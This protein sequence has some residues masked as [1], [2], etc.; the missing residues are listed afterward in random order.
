[1][2]A[3]QNEDQAV[4]L[5]VLRRLT[6]LDRLLAPGLPLHQ[7]LHVTAQTTGEMLGANV[8]V[9]YQLHPET[10]I[11]LVPPISWGELHQPQMLST[12]PERNAAVLEIM[13]RIEPFYAPNAPKGWG[14][15]LGIAPEKAA[16]GF[17]QR[18]QIVSSAGVPLLAGGRCLGV[19]FVNFR[20]PCQFNPVEKDLIEL[21]AARAVLAMQNTQQIEQERRT[22]RHISMAI[23]SEA[24]LEEAAGKILDELGKVVVYRKATMQLI[25][26]DNRKLLAYRGFEAENIDSELLRPISKDNL[27][28]R[29]V[30]NE[31]PTI[32][33]NPLVDPAWEVHSLTSDARSWVGV[34]LRFAGRLVGLITLDHDQPSFYSS[35]N[36]D[37]L[38]WCAGQAAIAIENARLHD[39]AQ[40]RIRDLRILNEI[41]E[42]IGS[43]LN[44]QDLLNAIA[45]RIRKHLQCTSCTFFFP[46]PI[47]DKMLL[48]PAVVDGDH[49]ERILSRTFKPGEGLVGLVY[50]SGEAI[51]LADARDHQNYAPARQR[52][53]VPRSMM[54]VPVQM[55]GR[56]V[57]VISADQD[58]YGWFSDNDLRLL[59]ALARQAGIA[60]QRNRGLE[61]LGKIGRRI[62]SAENVDEILKL[63]V[64]GAIDLSN[65]TSGVIYLVSTDGRQIIKTYKYPKKSFHPEPRMDKADGLTRQVIATGQIM[66]LVDVPRD[67]RVNPMLQQRV[68]SMIALPLKHED[69]VTGVLF[70]K[71]QKAHDFTETEIS[72]LSTLADQAATALYKAVLLTGLA[73]Q[74]RMHETLNAVELKLSGLHDEVQILKT[75]ARSTAKTLNCR[76]CSVFRVEHNSL[77]VV[78]SHGKLKSQLPP[79][80]T[81][82]LGQGIAGWVAQTGKP[83]LVPDTERDERFEP[84][85][86]EP[87]SRSSVITPIILDDEVYGVISAEDPRPL[88]FDEQDLRL[89]QT[90]AL[91]VSQALRNAQRITELEAL[92][93]AGRAITRELNL[94]FLFETLLGTV[95]QTLGCLSA[96]LFII[97]ANGDLVTHTQQGPSLHELDTLR[98]QVGRGLVGW[99]AEHRTSLNVADVRQDQ[100][101]IP[102][103][104]IPLDAPHSMLLAP[105][106]FKEH[107]VGV[108]S[109]DKDIVGG[110]S[111]SDQRLLETLA[112]QAATAYENARLFQE[113][114]QQADELALLHDVSARL[115]TLDLNDLL[116]MILEGAMRLTHT[117]V[118]VIYLL[119]EDG[120]RITQSLSRPTNF[121]PATFDLS[122]TH[123]IFET[124]QAVII[125]DVDQDDRVSKQVRAMGIRSFIGYPLKANEQVTG[126]LY[127]NDS[128]PHAF[129]PAELSL[130]ATLASQ[131]SAAI[132]NARLFAQGNKNSRALQRIVQIVRTI[133]AEQDPLPIILDEVIHL[134]NVADYGS[135]ALAEPTTGRLVF[136]AIFDNNAILSGAQIPLD[137]ITSD[138]KMGIIS[139][140]AQHGQAYRT[141]NVSK[142]PYYLR[143]RAATVSEMVVPF[144]TGDGQVIGTLNLESSERDAFTQEDMDLC[145]DLANVAAIA[146]EKGR[147]YHDLERRAS[148]LDALSQVARQVGSLPVQQEIFETVVRAARETLS[149][150]RCT[151]FVFD[152]K[153]LLVPKATSGI[154]PESVQRLVFRPGESLA[155]WVA[156][157][158]HSFR[159]PDANTDPHFLLDQHSRSDLPRPMVLAPLWIEG[160]VA[161]VLSADRE[162][163]PPFDQDDLRF[164]ETLAVEA[165]IFLLRRQRLEAIRRR[166][167]PYIVGGPIRDPEK[168]FGRQSLIHFILDGIHNNNFIVYG[169]RRIGK[170]SLLFQL[171]HHLNRISMSDE[172][173]FFKPV[174]ASLQGVSEE[175]FFSFLARQVQSATF[176]PLPKTADNSFDHIDLQEYL[177]QVVT[178]LDQQHSPRQVRLVLLLDELDVFM[179]YKNLV[180]DRFR[181]LFMTRCGEHL[182]MIATGLT[183]QRFQTRTSPWFNVSQI[184]EITQLSED[185]SWDLL[186]TPVAGY[187]SYDSA[188]LRILLNTSNCKPF[189]L[190]K[191][192]YQSVNVMLDRTLHPLHEQETASGIFQ[193]QLHDVEQAVNRVLRDKETEY[194]DFWARLDEEQRSILRN[195][196]QA[197]GLL[198]DTQSFAREELYNATYIDH[199]RSQLTKLFA[200]WLE[201][202]NP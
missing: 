30:S 189:E 112:A 124:S 195:A 130:S 55:G 199:G 39:A 72:L 186:T 56:T 41:G 133:G 190:Q 180:H 140:V 97:D 66:K 122:M 152:D 45:Q 116:D 197:D 37:V 79:G 14:K 167:N 44:T 63:I 61:L 84:S 119:S 80:R 142:D 38:N 141:G 129:S 114:R 111:K 82:R 87:P 200:M 187:Y 123:Y 33:S 81:F 102:P 181:N 6:Q 202:M 163:D 149:A 164:L 172:D 85:W 90:F 194:R 192:A 148:H 46:K 153:G 74:V 34:P 2:A 57:G 67:E 24:G 160:K 15:L 183:V 139:Y 83:A 105:M 134:F 88:I 43:Q 135:F 137:Q 173:F 11:A 168:F 64:E 117:E 171:E 136:K 20:Q 35:A 166:F 19:M 106:V 21:F 144:K 73:R 127:L 184:K 77:V 94:D 86:T 110:F 175:Y 18:E 4:S 169:E 78:A 59:Q 71:D 121:S 54:V 98:F 100:R 109:A 7:A 16:K 143:R 118:G 131:A 10:G 52:P 178:V 108:I 165:G 29:V 91:Q 22:I 1:M 95:K 69:R 193:I 191:L 68:H 154:Q 161:G 36:E 201:S 60:I 51:V 75:V 132:E 5:D 65:V 146:L 3:K 93:R 49:A 40:R 147:L 155:G 27:I 31:R 185:E 76:N 58:T 107:L 198:E 28:R 104:S 150:V 151:L 138:G 99:V 126:V 96:T 125:S 159:T 13:H 70:L 182:R 176:T 196:A 174:F 157:E 170:T 158:G 177:E 26:H 48:A 162:G 179:D 47:N 101:F 120:E 103:S 92:N 50:Q 53:D 17:I 128:Q 8:V 25:Q 62:N 23:N 115:M 145:Q 42:I 12:S 188:A 113:S 156:Q 89:M 9:L 32:L